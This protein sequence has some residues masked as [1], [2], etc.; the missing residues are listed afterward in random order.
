MLALVV[1]VN[2]RATASCA[3]ARIAASCS[4]IICSIRWPKS[5][6]LGVLLMPTQSHAPRQTLN[7]TRERL[8]VRYLVVEMSAALVQGA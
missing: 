5:W 7:P 4:A 3:L 8:R 2:A 1:V 6:A